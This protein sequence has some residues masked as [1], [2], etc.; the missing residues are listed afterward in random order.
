MLT[1]FVEYLMVFRVVGR[2]VE[3]RC[4]HDLTKQNSGVDPHSRVM[5]N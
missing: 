5:A 3:E 2:G 4:D 1:F